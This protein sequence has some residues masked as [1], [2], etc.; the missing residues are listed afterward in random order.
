MISKKIL[1]EFTKSLLMELV[2][3]KSSLLSPQDCIL[4]LVAEL[5]KQNRLVRILGYSETESDLPQIGFSEPRRGYEI[6]FTSEEDEEKLHQMCV[7]TVV[8]LCSKKALR[9]YQKFTS[10]KELF[11]SDQEVEDYYR[12]IKEILNK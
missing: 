4:F 1:D 8:I 12:K 6:I 3:N 5:K 11:C 7:A 9:D 2:D 10:A